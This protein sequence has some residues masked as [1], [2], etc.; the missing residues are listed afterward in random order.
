MFE[1]NKLNTVFDEGE[2]NNQS[3][4]QSENESPRKRRVKSASAKHVSTKGTA[5]G[6]AMY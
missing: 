2:S 5:K 1:E 6:G 4:D 3:F